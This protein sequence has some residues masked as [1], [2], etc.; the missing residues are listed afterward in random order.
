MFSWIT[1]HLNRHLR[2]WIILGLSTIVWPTAAQTDLTDTPIN[3]LPVMSADNAHLL[4]E[5][6][7]IEFKG[8]KIRGIAWDKTDSHL[9]VASSTVWSYDLT[10][11]TL[12][13][14]IEQEGILAAAFHAERGLVAYSDGQDTIYLADMAL[15]EVQKFT[16]PIVTALAFS[17]DGRYLVSGGA[18]GVVQLWDIDSRQLLFT[19]S[20]T[21]DP[22]N[23]VQDLDFSVNDTL[24]FA[25]H[26]RRDYLWDMSKLMARNG[27]SQLS[28]VSIFGGDVEGAAFGI[29][30]QWAVFS[31]GDERAHNQAF[32]IQAFP[33]PPK[34]NHT[35]I[36]LPSMR[37]MM[38][39]RDETINDL[40][41]DPN[42]KLLLAASTDGLVRIWSAETGEVL[43]TL[44]TQGTS[45]ETIAIH[46]EGTLIAT[47]DQRGTVRLWGVY[48]PPAR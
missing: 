2:L 5:I 24:I 37:L 27:Q 25:S 7:H 48:Q 40:A 17:T 6:A 45:I 34:D 20:D 4:I 29:H 38:S 10:T 36:P 28:A 33:T 30:N 12:A 42:G 3:T 21:N 8:G 35:L 39:S 19:F 13:G 9:I 15:N 18:D 47:G 14:R 22:D 46:P 41:F 26:Q 23:G 1:A 32:N 43:A 44:Q 31:V 16:Q 11:Q